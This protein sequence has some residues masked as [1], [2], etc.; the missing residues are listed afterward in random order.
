VAPATCPSIT[1]LYAGAL[2]KRLANTQSGRKFKLIV[3]AVESHV[4]WVWNDADY[5]PECT[6][7]ILHYDGALSKPA[8]ELEKI[9]PPHT[10]SSLI[11]IAPRS[12]LAALE[13]KRFDTGE[14]V[15]PE[16]AMADDEVVVF[17]G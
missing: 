5:R 9:W 6:F 17:M 12:S 2:R 10:D 15:C 4:N 13:M 14:W 1:S 11:T 16:Q 7:R 3:V 8:A